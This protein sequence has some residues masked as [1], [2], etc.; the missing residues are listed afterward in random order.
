MEDQG[1][2]EVVESEAGTSTLSMA[3]AVK[4]TAKDKKVQAHLLPCLPDDLLM[5][6][7]KKKTRKEVWNSLKVCFVGAD[8]VN[9]AQL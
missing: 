1:V 8:R 3:D 7:A 2:W 4:A 6:V 5:Q 9:D